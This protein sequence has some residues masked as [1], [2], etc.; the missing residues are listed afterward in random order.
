MS[1]IMNLLNVYGYPTLFFALM[2]ELIFIP[3]P[4]EALMSYVG[5][6][7]FHGKMNYLLSVLTAWGGGIVGVSI[8]YWLGYKLGAPFFRKYGKYIHMGPDK[9]D[10]VTHWYTKY[11]KVLLVFCYFVPGVRHVASIISGVIRLPFRSFA[12]FSYIGVFLWTGTFISLGYVLGPQWDKYQGQ[13]KKWLVLAMIII[14]LGVVCYL[15]LKANWPFIKESARL[16]FESFFKRYKSFLRIKLILILLLAAF[17]TLF[18]LMIGMIQ[19]FVSNDAGTFNE[20]T[21]SIVYF[22]FND[23]WKSPL[24]DIFR[25]SS[26]PMLG[27]VALLTMATIL[28]N[29]ENQWLELLFYGLSIA[30]GFLFSLGIRWLFHFMLGSRVI[31]TDFPDQR[32]FLITLF[33][34][35]LLMAL[36]RH[37]HNYILMTM[38][39]GVFLVLLLAFG[40][41][42]I[43]LSG[44]NPNDL[45][46]GN[47]FGAAWGSG[48]IL[49]LELFRFLSL[50]KKSEQAVH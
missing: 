14:A 50:I 47:V 30:G 43:Y 37:Q 45:L 20:V 13:I 29:R 36:I 12:L 25:L 6:L 33:W 3:I 11:G 41:S 26:W 46:A 15:V 17:V 28:L 35:L 42:G 44:L 24:G 49:L 2:L 22:F 39:F 9:M 34:G 31:S 48:M 4:N 19:D 8:S 32:A 27:A 16:I 1:G 10:K 40:V 23:N 21:R 18:T 7:S 38:L 5:I